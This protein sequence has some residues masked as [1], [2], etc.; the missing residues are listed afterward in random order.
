MSVCEEHVES[1]IVT[2]TDTQ[3][4][5]GLWCF[6]HALGAPCCEF[7]IGASSQGISAKTV[8]FIHPFSVYVFVCARVQEFFLIFRHTCV[9]NLHVSLPDKDKI[10]K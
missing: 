6:V 2:C 3:A 5:R 1:C 10:A 8:H 9:H 7:H 4:D